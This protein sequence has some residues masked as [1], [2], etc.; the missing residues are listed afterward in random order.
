MKR[1]KNYKNRLSGGNRLFSEKL[2]KNLS[3]FYCLNNSKIKI[4]KEE[5]N[6]LTKCCDNGLFMKKK[7]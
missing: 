3:S 5:I 2:Y 7:K 4:A 1:N 6:Q